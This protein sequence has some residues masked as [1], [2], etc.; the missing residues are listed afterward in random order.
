MKTKVFY[1][2]VMKELSPFVAF[3]AAGWLIAL[4]A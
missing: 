1:N 4:S 3:V 2:R